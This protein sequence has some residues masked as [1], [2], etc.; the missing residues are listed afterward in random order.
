MTIPH[1]DSHTFG[2]SSFILLRIVTTAFTSFVIP[3]KHTDFIKG[4]PVAVCPPI[5]PQFYTLRNVMLSSEYMVIVRVIWTP[6]AG[7]AQSV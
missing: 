2:R 7:I 5:R 1:V 6:W 4:Q 3:K